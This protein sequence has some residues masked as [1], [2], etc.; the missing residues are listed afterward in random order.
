M[1]GGYLFGLP[2]GQLKITLNALFDSYDDDYDVKPRD[3]FLYRKRDKK[4]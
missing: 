2:A 3:F 4:K 1:A